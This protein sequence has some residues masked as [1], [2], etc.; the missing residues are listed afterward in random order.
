MSLTVIK[1]IWDACLRVRLRPCVSAVCYRWLHAKAHMSVAL[2]WYRSVGTSV[3]VSD[4]LQTWYFT[5]QLFDLEPFRSFFITQKRLAHWICLLTRL[6]FFHGGV[7]RLETDLKTEQVGQSRLQ[8]LFL[9]FLN[10]NTKI[11]YSLT[12][13]Q[14]WSSCSAFWSNPVCLPSFQ[15]HSWRLLF[16]RL[17]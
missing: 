11:S 1:Y 4:A 16:F 14:L 15:R 9:L 5:N 8:Q 10:A 7:L 6:L 13:L 3:V 12:N 17:S 2:G